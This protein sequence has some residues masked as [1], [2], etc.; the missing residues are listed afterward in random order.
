M[1]PIVSLIFAIVAFAVFVISLRSLIRSRQEKKKQ[2]QE[3]YIRDED[4]DR[5]EMM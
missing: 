1:N 5:K 4:G 3:Q 2:Q